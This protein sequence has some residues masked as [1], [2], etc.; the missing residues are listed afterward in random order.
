[1][2][3]T[4]AAM[5]TANLGF[6]SVPVSFVQFFGQEL[7]ELVG[8]LF[9]GGHQILERL[10]FRYPEARENVGSRVPVGVFE[11]VEILEHIIHGAAEA[12]GDVAVTA[13]MTITQVEVAEKRVVEKA[14]E[15]NILVTSRPSIVD[16]A[17]AVSPTRGYCGVRR[18]IARIFLCGVVKEF[19]M[20]ALSTWIPS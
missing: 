13:L 2:D 17:E 6:L 5:F 20:L 16:A 8:I 14:L 1:M 12:M 4:V 19:V 3:D 10:L 15:D 18:Y 11:R 9:F 7:E